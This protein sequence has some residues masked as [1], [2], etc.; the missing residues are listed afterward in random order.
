MSS[1]GFLA[2]CVGL[3]SAAPLFLES[4]TGGQLALSGVPR[5]V[6]VALP[7]L[8]LAGLPRTNGSTLPWLAFALP[9]AGLA[10]GLDLADGA[11]TDPWLPLGTTAL[12]LGWAYLAQVAADHD[13]GH[14][15][16]P[17]LW[18]FFVVLPPVLLVSL[19]WASPASAPLPTFVHDLS[20]LVWLH[21]APSS[22]LRV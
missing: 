13:E 21:A 14:A 8:V 17:W 22:P 15:R 1:F 3:L 10:L 6:P 9:P 7:W 4:L 20:P 5:F 18:L 12:A 11:L 16:Y 19:R 2:V